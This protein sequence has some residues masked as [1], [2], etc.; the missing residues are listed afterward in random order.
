MQATTP[1]DVDNV[2]HNQSGGANSPIS[3]EPEASGDSN[4]NGGGLMQRVK[5]WFGSVR[6]VTNSFFVKILFLLFHFFN[7]LLF[8]LPQFP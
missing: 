3:E 7:V 1:N 8:C 6:V 5:G 2:N 4:A